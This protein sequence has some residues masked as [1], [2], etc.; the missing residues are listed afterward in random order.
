MA[1]SSTT[2][3]G[4]LLS[5]AIGLGTAFGSTLN[6]PRRPPPCV[7]ALPDGCFIGDGTSLSAAPSLLVR[8]AASIAA[9]SLDDADT[10]DKPS[11]ATAAAGA[12]LRDCPV[13]ACLVAC[14]AAC[15]G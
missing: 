7:A 3:A 1:N 12:S 6:S 9:E 15:F 11:R 13:E 2:R 5:S 8:A 4:R 14:L 10:S